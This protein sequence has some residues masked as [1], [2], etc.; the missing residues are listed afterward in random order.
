MRPFSR[1]RIPFGPLLLPM[2]LVISL[3]LLTFLPHARHL[4]ATGNAAPRV[5]AAAAVLMDLDT[6]QVLYAKNRAA[7]FYPASVAKILTA[8]VVLERLRLDEVVTV[9]P[10]AANVEGSKMY[11]R[12]GERITVENLLY[13]LMLASGNDAARA[14]AEHTAGSEAAFAVLMNARARA[15]GATRSRFV[16][17]SGLPHPDQV[18]TAE[19]LARIT[20]AAL[21]NPVFS[22]IV[23]TRQKEI[24]WVDGRRWTAYNHNYA[25]GSGG[26]DGVKNGYTIAARHTYVAS[27]TREGWRLIAVVLRT[28]KQGKF[29]DARALLDHGFQAFDPV[30]V[31]RPLEPVAEVPVR[32]GTADAVP[33]LLPRQEG[34]RLPVGAGRERSDYRVSVT[35]P[36][37]LTAPVRQGR[38][39]GRLTVSRA[40]E[41]L[42]T[43]PLVTGEEIPAD[44]RH[45]GRASP[46]R[47][48]LEEFWRLLRRA[49]P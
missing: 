1:Y 44:P 30:T 32:G 24:Q 47:L 45:T 7:P 49:L 25:L 3:Q 26:I 37:T 38:V 34:I 5:E 16:N 11:L 36:D 40:G 9:S 22:K 46:S 6:G 13:G 48:L 15:A 20:R 17:A 35:A 8:L 42:V 31:A 39:V 28:S 41:D 43:Y 4:P 33:L 12:A 27:A 14:L 10:G 23:A 19:D 2:L 18:T 21:E 29:R